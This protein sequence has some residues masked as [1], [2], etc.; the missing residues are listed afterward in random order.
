MES[1]KKEEIKDLVLLAEQGDRAAYG[2]LYE[3]TGRSVYFSCLKLLANA[4][5]AEDITQETFLKIGGAH[6]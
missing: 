6:V 4:Q 1:I 2:R 5:L 3:E